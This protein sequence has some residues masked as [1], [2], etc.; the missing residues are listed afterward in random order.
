MCCIIYGIKL[1]LHWS[2]PDTLAFLRFETNRALPCANE[3][4]VRREN[5]PSGVKNN[6]ECC[7]RNALNQ[8]KI[9][10]SCKSAAY[11]LTKH[12]HSIAW[13]AFTQLSFLQTKSMLLVRKSHVPVKCNFIKKSDRVTPMSIKNLTYAHND[14]FK[15]QKIL[16]FLGN[17]FDLTPCQASVEDHEDEFQSSMV[18]L[19]RLDDDTPHPSLWQNS[20]GL[21][22]SLLTR[23][24]LHNHN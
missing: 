8:W 22:T 18:Y 19:S 5:E 17:P 21:N 24:Q 15:R 14:W 7:S 16:D 4:K 2:S 10:L 6:S 11:L 13:T 12:F 1:L 23:T 20:D 3:S 9:F